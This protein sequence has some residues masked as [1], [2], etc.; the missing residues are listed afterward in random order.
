M[1]E[2]GNVWLFLL[3]GSFPVLGNFFLWL[4]KKVFRFGKLKLVTKVMNFLNTPTFFLRL[5]LNLFLMYN[6]YPFA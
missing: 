3:A 2:K 4:L 6:P 1:V 5:F